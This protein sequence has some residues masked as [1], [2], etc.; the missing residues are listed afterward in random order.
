MFQT[1][2]NS[3]LLRRVLWI[4]V[5]LTIVSSLKHKNTQPPYIFN[6]ENLRNSELQ[7]GLRRG[8]DFIALCG[9]DGGIKESEKTGNIIYG[10][11]II[12]LKFFVSLSVGHYVYF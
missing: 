11:P 6:R 1:S 2:D 9:M 12:E 10:R 4:N 8:L 5:E 7:N 3:E